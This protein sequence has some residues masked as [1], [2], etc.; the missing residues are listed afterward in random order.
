MASSGTASLSPLQEEPPVASS[1]A[2]LAGA[3]YWLPAEAP[4]GGDNAPIQFIRIDDEGKCHVTPEAAE[5]LRSL[6]TGR[7]LAVVGIA[8][9][10][11]TGKSYLLN[12]L[13]GTQEGFEIGSTINA[14][15]KGLWIWGRPLQLAPDFQCLLLDTEGL[16]SCQRTASCDMQIFSLCILLS[17][18]F[19]YNSMG[20]IDEQAIDDLHLVLHLAKH[21]HVQSRKGRDSEDKSELSQYFPDF[22]WVLRDFHLQFDEASGVTSEYGYLEQSLKATPGQDDKNKV[23]ETIKALFQERDCVTLVRPVEEE[24]DLRR[25]QKVPYEKLREPFREKVEAFVS[26]VLGAARPKEID[27]SLCSGAMLV[28]LAEMY[29]ESI[30]NSVVPTIQSAWTA[31]VNQQLRLSLQDAVRVYKLEMNEKIA[32]LIPMNEDELRDHHKAAKAEALK[33][34]L[35]PR[36]EEEEPRLKEYREELTKRIRQLYEAAKTDNAAASRDQCERVAREIYSSQIERNLGVYKSLED[37][38]HDWAQLRE[39]YMAKTAGPAQSEVL[40]TWLFQRMTE[41]VQ[42]VNETLRNELLER[43]EMGLADGSRYRGQ[44]RGDL[45]HGIGVLVRRDGQ[46]YEGTFADGRAH[47]H[48]T[49]RTATGSEYQG[50]WSN[51]QAHGYGKLVQASGISYEGEWQHNEKTG[52]GTERWPD[53]ASYEGEFSRGAK[54]GSGMYLSGS[55]A[56]YDGQFRHDLMDG[57]GRYTADDGCVLKGQWRQGHMSG[58]GEALWP[59]GSRYEGAYDRDAKNGEGS[60]TWPDGRIYRGQWRDG[61]QDGNG[62]AIDHAGNETK[63]IW[64]D[65]KPISVESTSG[66]LIGGPNQLPSFRHVRS[67]AGSRGGPLGKRNPP[68]PESKEYTLPSTSDR[69]LESFAAAHGVPPP[70]PVLG[71]KLDVEIY[72]ILDSTPKE[73]SKSNQANNCR[74]Q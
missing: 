13:L 50:Q 2:A 22:L 39:V 67:G 74:C 68:E 70:A 31:V 56:Q 71:G 47:G 35:A 43:P 33:V 4:S 32:H 27:G 5:L 38:M 14:C 45:R 3:E 8:G 11:R 64:R 25:I 41:S 61:T 46:W 40:S 16:G 52:K 18:Y 15:T 26:K 58:V 66:K 36:F 44:W 55:A 37:L 34:F 21:I 10:Y 65:G 62:V 42:L 12:R 1:A 20:T 29:C 30:N 63:G 23:R 53:G 48:G 69:V 28:H 19:I 60:L 57:E 49:F 17:S 24:S 73:G 59:D 72:P 6:G 7:R 51:D 9:L 54:H